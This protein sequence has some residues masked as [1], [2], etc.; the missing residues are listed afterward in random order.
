MSIVVGVGI[1]IVICWP[2]P[3]GYTY[4]GKTVQEWFGEFADSQALQ[5]YPAT[6]DVG[7]V[8]LAAF[9]AMGTNAAPFLTS[10]IIRDLTPS[11]FERWAQKLPSRFQPMSKASEAS[12]AAILLRHCVSLPPSMRETLAILAFTSPN[13]EQANAAMFAVKEIDSRLMT[14][15][16]EAISSNYQFR[17]EIW[18]RRL[19]PPPP[20]NPPF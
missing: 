18:R 1:A 11:R 6:G 17:E 13:D 7:P 4:Q 10:R 5:D 9:N 2:H 16:I 12:A 19:P 3:R 14:N 15:L 8:A 20:Q